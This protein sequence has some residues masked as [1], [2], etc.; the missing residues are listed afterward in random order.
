MKAQSITL[1]LGIRVV[2]IVLLVG[3]I[4]V[5]IHF[6]ARNILLGPAITLQ[7]DPAVL[8]SERTITLTGSA[9]NI[10]RLALNGREINTTASGAFTQTLVLQE[11]YTIIELEAQDRFGRTVSLRRE[12]VY[13][14]EAT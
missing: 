9:Q 6:Q 3:L 10:V 12:Y 13:A 1:G 14:P 7:N 4:L 8:Q 2:G 5:Y 11:G